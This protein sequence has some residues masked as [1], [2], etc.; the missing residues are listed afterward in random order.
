[1]ISLLLRQG[2]DTATIL[3]IHHSPFVIL[4][5][6]WSR[7]LYKPSHLEA[8]RNIFIALCFNLQSSLSKTF[9]YSSY[10][11]KVI[12]VL[13]WSRTATGTVGTEALAHWPPAM[14]SLVVP[15]NAASLKHNRQDSWPVGSRSKYSLSSSTTCS[16]SSRCTELPHYSTSTSWSLQPGRALISW[17]ECGNRVGSQMLEFIWNYAKTRDFYLHFKPSI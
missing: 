12:D 6:S 3:L 8:L 10:H 7:G 16:R 15:T 11:A 4:S 5:V 9:K 14:P 13:T 1:M 2:I 17:R